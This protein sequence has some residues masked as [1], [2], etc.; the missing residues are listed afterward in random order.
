MRKRVLSLCMAFAMC[1]SFLPSPILAANE[2]AVEKIML[3]EDISE[4]IQPTDDVIPS[5]EPER[6]SKVVVHR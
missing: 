3:S 2:G 6:Y 5:V 4:S 1:L